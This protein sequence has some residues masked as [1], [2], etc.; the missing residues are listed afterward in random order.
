MNDAFARFEREL[1]TSLE[2]GTF[3]KVSL[4]EPIAPGAD[5]ARNLTA[6]VIDRRGK[7]ALS[8]VWRYQTRDITKSFA[9]EDGARELAAQARTF[10]RSARLFTT[11]GD[12]AL[13]RPESGPAK[14]KSFRAVI[15]I[16]PGTAHDREKK[17]LFP[18][19]APFLQA[20][21]VTNSSG[22]PRA[23]MSDKLRQI[24]RFA[25][26]VDHLL[27]RTPAL[28]EK[29]TVRVIDLGAGKGY[30]TF[31]LH[32]LLSLR[33]IAAEVTGIERR[34]DLAIAAENNARRIGTKGLHFRGGEIADLPG[35]KESID[36]LVALH[37]CDTATDDA[38]HLGVRAGAALLL[39]SP[40]C[41]KELRNQLAPPAPL[42]DIFKHGIFRE[43]ETEIVTDAVR[44]LILE[45]HGYETRVFEFVAAAHTV[46]NVMIAGIKRTRPAEQVDAA[47]ERL[48]ALLKFYGIR[49]QRLVA[50]LQDGR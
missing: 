4:S 12:W 23:A 7:Q 2:G 3:V 9:L 33:G 37:A 21:G 6:R 28:R 19:D 41:Q 36:L 30:L 17:Q 25:E 47:R 35:A 26:L 39:V 20:L 32:A 15:T 40:C 38:L 46:R 34:A 44:A 13:Q 45:G 8:L 1:R 24:E 22:T 42:T 10:F 18:P 11:A 49:Q 43:R 16:V 29:Q 48:N 5:A 31:A 14:V 27:A 50:L